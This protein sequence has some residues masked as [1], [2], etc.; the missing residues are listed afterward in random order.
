MGEN[1]NCPPGPVKFLSNIRSLLRS[2]EMA[3]KPAE[4]PERGGVT[5][6]T[7]SRP[8]AIFPFWCAAL[9][10]PVNQSVI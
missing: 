3:L 4:M 1:P 2:A 10:F 7:R 5:G 6:L 8:A 9:H